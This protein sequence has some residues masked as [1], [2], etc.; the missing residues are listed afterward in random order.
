MPEPYQLASFYNQKTN[1]IEAFDEII[2]KTHDH[3]DLNVRC[4]HV[5]EYEQRQTKQILDEIRAANSNKKI[6]VFQPYGSSIGFMN[7]EPYDNTSRSLRHNHY[8]EISKALQDITVIIY[9]SP[10]KFMSEHDN[11]ISINNWSPY[12]RVLPGFINQC[13][14]FIGVDSCGQ[15]IAY[16]L[17][18][19][20][21]VLMG[22]TVDRNYTYPDHFKIIR[23][24]DRQPVYNPIRLSAGDD[25]HI[26][27]LN[28]GILD[29]DKYEL[30]QIISHL[31]KEIINT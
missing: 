8:M 28:Q 30:Q 27:R 5:S 16:A 10:K 24:A 31:R 19:P 9:A 29:F 1:L 13:D 2:N 12:F 15:H 26:H 20:G 23:K 6:V 25:E 14:Y 17:N 7:G 22:S 11:N 18:K 4:L 21:T 3:T